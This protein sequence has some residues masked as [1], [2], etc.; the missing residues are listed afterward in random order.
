[1]QSTSIK[2][3]KTDPLKSE[4]TKSPLNPQHEMINQRAERT[5]VSPEYLTGLPTVYR[6]IKSV[7]RPLPP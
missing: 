1:M 6:T 2:P 5:L 3:M 7:P 4:L